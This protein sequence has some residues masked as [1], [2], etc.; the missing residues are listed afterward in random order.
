[1][2]DIEDIGWMSINVVGS[3]ASVELKEKAKVPKVDDY[4]VPANVKAT[5]DGLILSINTTQGEAFFDSGSAVVKDQLIVSGVVEDKLGGVSLVRANAE[6]VAQTTRKEIFK[7]DKN[8]P[9]ITFEK[10]KTLHTVE[11]LGLKM[12]CGFVF[13]D[14]SECAVRS[15]KNILSFFDT[16]LPVGLISKRVYSKD[17]ETT[18]LKKQSAQNILKK[19]AMLYEGLV[20]KDC[21]V[22]SVDYNFN[23]NDKQYILEVTYTC[24][25]DIA[26]QQDIDTENVKIERVLP[27]EDKASP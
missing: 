6:V 2:L 19:R 26:Y 10:D 22:I 27:T 5:R 16:D 17:V 4:H 11:L 7:V 23:E 13:A 8:Y 18:L 20:L 25:E 1:M 12:P 9:V 24:K 15:D 3:H 21:E 14:E